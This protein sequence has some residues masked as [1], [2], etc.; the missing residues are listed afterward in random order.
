MTGIFEIS[1][2]LLF[3]DLFSIFMTFKSYKVSLLWF[4][5][6]VFRKIKNFVPIF[7]FIT[8]QNCLHYFSRI[9]KKSHWKPGNN[10]KDGF[11]AFGSHSNVVSNKHNQGSSGFLE[12]WF[13]KQYPTSSIRTYVTS[14]LVRNASSQ[15]LLE[16][17]KIRNSMDGAQ[18]SVWATPEDN[19]DAWTVFL[20]QEQF[21]PI[22]N[23]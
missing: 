18:P 21:C 14:A 19:S 10:T 11:T 12:Q 17:S 1:S 3:Q 22:E 2:V 23:I 7:T 5:I 8:M 4:C 20:R 6:L 13:S 9:T 16:T 15:A